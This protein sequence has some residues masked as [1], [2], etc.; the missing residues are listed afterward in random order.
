MNGK[1]IKIILLFSLIS[2][3]FWY[4][5]LTPYLFLV[6]NYSIEQY[7]IWTQTA[8]IV[9]TISAFPFYIFSKYTH[10][11]TERIIG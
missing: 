1:E 2:N 7:I 4:S 5:I 11:L 10:R 6:V 8:W 3:V 9:N